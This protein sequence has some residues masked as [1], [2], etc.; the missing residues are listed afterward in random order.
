MREA[1]KKIRYILS[2]H[3]RGKFSLADAAIIG[4]LISIPSA[5]L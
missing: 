1:G 5:G 4:G 3:D 2:H